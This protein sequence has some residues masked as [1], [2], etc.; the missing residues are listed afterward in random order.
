MRL[1]NL[2]PSLP[3]HEELAILANRQNAAAIKVKRAKAM[4]AMDCASGSPALSDSKT[5]KHSGLGVRSLERLRQRICEVGAL[6]ALERKPRLTPPVAPKVTGEVEARI[7][8]IACTKPPKDCSRWTMQLIA[9]RMI[10]LKIVESI[11]DETVR[12]TLKK[13]TL[14][15]G[16]KSAGASRRR[17]MLPL[18]G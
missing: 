9:D 14:N 2:L 1:R 6:G 11:S 10:E 3:C 4:L 17:K 12:I 13:T 16:G 18:A 5:S 15:H 7:V 8:Q